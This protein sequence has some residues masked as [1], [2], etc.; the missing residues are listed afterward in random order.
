MFLHKCWVIR[1]VEQVK[2]SDNHCLFQ[3]CFFPTHVKIL[4]GRLDLCFLTNACRYMTPIHAL[5]LK[6]M[7]E[8]VCI[9]DLWKSWCNFMKIM[10]KYMPQKKK[11]N[12]NL[13]V[14]VNFYPNVKFPQSVVSVGLMHKTFGI[15]VRK[16]CFRSETTNTAYFWNEYFKCT[17]LLNICTILFLSRPCYD[18]GC[19][20]FR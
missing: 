15:N 16:F 2:K 7:A 11:N 1:G 3:L 10:G 14:Q 6:N 4:V 8:C 13:F 12:A 9:L 18:I 20:I 19:T 17:I 5:I